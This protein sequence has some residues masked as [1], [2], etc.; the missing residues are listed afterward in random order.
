MS[1]PM[2]LRVH[3]LAL[4]GLRCH[5]CSY[6]S[7]EPS[8]F[9]VDHLKPQALGGSDHVRNLVVACAPCNESRGKKHPSRQREWVSRS[10]HVRQSAEERFLD[11]FA[12]MRLAA[13]AIR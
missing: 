3:V 8:D 4:R 5:W 10:V 13:G 2:S 12:Q 7:E 11:A 6:E 1:I 9:H